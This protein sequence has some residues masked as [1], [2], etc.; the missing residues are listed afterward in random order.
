MQLRY[1][2]KI[3]TLRLK[4]SLTTEEERDFTSAIQVK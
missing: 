1:H 2:L 4:Y 3:I